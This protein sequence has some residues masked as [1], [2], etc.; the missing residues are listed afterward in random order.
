[1]ARKTLALRLEII[2]TGQRCILEAIRGKYDVG[3]RKLC[4]TARRVWD[5]VLTRPIL[6]SIVPF[7]ASNVTIVSKLII[8]I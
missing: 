8:T 5:N 7:G 1:M 4:L 2:F 3:N 6:K